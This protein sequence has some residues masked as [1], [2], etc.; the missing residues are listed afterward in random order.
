MI[1]KILV[2][3]EDFRTGDNQ[4]AQRPGDN[5]RILYSQTGVLGYLLVA[6]SYESYLSD[7]LL[8]PDAGIL[9]RRSVQDDA[10]RLWAVSV[11]R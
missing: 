6:D 8:P 1:A 10:F 9:R 4:S 3:L 11:T 5:I 2:E 7:F